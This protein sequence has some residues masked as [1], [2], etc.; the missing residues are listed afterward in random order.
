MEP[1]CISP[2]VGSAIEKKIDRMEWYAGLPVS[3]WRRILALHTDGRTLI[4][5]RGVSTFAR[6]CLTKHILLRFVSYHN[7]TAK[8]GYQR[9]FHQ[10]YSAD[11]PVQ[12]SVRNAVATYWPALLR[13]HHYSTPSRTLQKPTNCE[14][15]S[16]STI[17]TQPCATNAS[18]DSV[19]HVYSML[20]NHLVDI[21]RTDTSSTFAEYQMN[22]V[23]VAVLSVDWAE[24]LNAQLM[25]HNDNSASESSASELERLMHDPNTLC[26][27][28][29]DLIS[30]LL[31][32]FPRDE[33]NLRR[34]YLQ[35]CN[36]DTQWVLSK[37]IWS[38]LRIHD[39][40]NLII[41]ERKQSNTS[42][43]R[44]IG[45]ND[46]IIFFDWQGNNL[47][48]DDHIPVY[49]ITTVEEKQCL[50]YKWLITDDDANEPRIT[51]PKCIFS[52]RAFDYEPHCH[53]ANEQFKRTIQ[54]LK[55][56]GAKFSRPVMVTRVTH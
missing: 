45:E 4:Q 34:L 39:V 24:Q 29:V 13:P 12:L 19:L 47:S 15:S 46:R 52:V 56:C 6:E 53:Y 44:C 9:L 14:V 40:V 17:T 55:D 36:G 21:P 33:K 30:D 3:I 31:R 37:P 2:V 43:L 26:L 16:L 10:E 35:V 28:Y 22:Q 41:D 18:V 7:G 32:T 49:D 48:L 54:V 5:F 20:G 11:A 1:N 38:H 8:S 42:P 25:S 51:N 50:E 23:N 27:G